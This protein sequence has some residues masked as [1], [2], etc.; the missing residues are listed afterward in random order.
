MKDRAPSKLADSDLWTLRHPLHY[1]KHASAAVSPS[2]LIVGRADLRNFEGFL[3][4][5]ACTLWK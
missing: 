3:R 5:N 4:G 1:P 2:D